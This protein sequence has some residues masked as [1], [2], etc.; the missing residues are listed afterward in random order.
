VS[1]SKAKAV[2]PISACSRQ[3]LLKGCGSKMDISC[4]RACK[5]L[6]ICSLVLISCSPARPGSDG[7]ATEPVSTTLSPATLPYWDLFPLSSDPVGGWVSYRMEDSDISFQYPSVYQEGTCG[8]IFTEDKVTASYQCRLIGFSGSSIQI[9]VFEV[10]ESALD[11]IAREGQPP[12]Q[13]KLVTPV[14][15]FSLGGI[16]AVR[17]VSMNPDSKTL[18]YSK[19]ALAIYRDKL[20]AF[21]YLHHPELPS[22]DAPPLSEQQVYEYV[23]STLEFLE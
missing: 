12:P 16:P 18:G 11:K 17:Y 19:A 6:F 9:H 2:R 21:S 10:W 23:L 20:Y 15:R 14:E 5:A 13:A 1:N 7:T 8:T 4:M 3:H 22:C